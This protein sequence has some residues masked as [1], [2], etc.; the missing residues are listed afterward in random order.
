MMLVNHAILALAFSLKREAHSAL[1]CFEPSSPRRSLDL[2]PICPQWVLGE[3][4]LWITLSPLWRSHSREG[5]ALCEPSCP[6]SRLLA[7]GET[8]N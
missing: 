2:S 4:T 1:S 7:Q 5:G 3:F 6:V 8:H